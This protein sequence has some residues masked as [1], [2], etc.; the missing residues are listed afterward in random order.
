VDWEC[1]TKLLSSEQMITVYQDHIEELEDENQKLKDKIKFLE[2][3]LDYKSMGRP[4]E[5]ELDM[6]SFLSIGR[7]QK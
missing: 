1:E 2:Q 6:Q 5:Q 4:A 3:Q 7:N